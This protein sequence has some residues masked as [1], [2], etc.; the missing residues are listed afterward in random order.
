MLRRQLCAITLLLTV[1]LH[2]C[3]R[4]N[5]QFTQIRLMMTPADLKFYFCASD[6]PKTAA[7]KPASTFHTSIHRRRTEN[8]VD[9]RLHTSAAP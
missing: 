4:K 5:K 2:S 3:F 8:Y 9:C 6:N 1:W 7:A